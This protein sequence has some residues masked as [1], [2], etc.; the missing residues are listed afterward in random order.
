MLHGIP[1]DR[2]VVTGAQCFDDWFDWRPARATK[3]APG[4]VSTRARPT[5]STRAARRGRASPEADF[6]RA[7]ACRAPRARRRPLADAGVLVRPHPKRPRRVARRSPP[8]TGGRSSRGAGARADRPSRRRTTSTR[9]TTR[10]AVV[11]LNTSAMIEAAIVGRS[12]LTV[13]DPDRARSARDAPLPLPARSRAGCSGSR[14]RSGSTPTSSRRPSPGPRTTAPV[15][16][17]RFVAEFVR[18]SARRPATPLFV[19]ESSG[20]PALAAP[21]PERT[22]A[23]LLPLRALLA[24]L[25]ARAGRPAPAGDD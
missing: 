25:A 14:T 5:S 2:V 19:D 11:G 10:A 6:V 12:V 9:S 20:S 3:F 24:P 15:A 17:R 23:P 21:R 7:L 1:A 4:S 16:Q 18:P 8:A 22:P 13:L